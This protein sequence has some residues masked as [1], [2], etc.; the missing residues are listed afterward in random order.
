MAT[1]GYQRQRRGNI[2]A[3]CLVIFLQLSF[4]ACLSAPTELVTEDPK[5]SA[6]Q[7]NPPASPTLMSVTSSRNHSDPSITTNNLPGSNATNPIPQNDGKTTTIQKTTQPDGKKVTTK[8]SSVSSTLGSIDKVSD[9]TN[10]VQ[11][12]SLG[13]DATATKPTTQPPS[14]APT[15]TKAATPETEKPENDI[16]DA[17]TNPTTVESIDALLPTDDKESENTN[18]L[19]DTNDKYY[20]DN[21]DDDDS[22][23]YI[24]STND[25]IFEL[26]DNKD[27]SKMKQ[28]SQI[29]EPNSNDS[30]N[31]DSNFFFHLVILVLLVAI[32]YITYHNKRK[33]LLLVQSRRWKEGLCSRNNVE[34]RRLDQNVNEAM[35]SLKMTKDYI[36]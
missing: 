10:P 5:G 30:E 22:E 1:H 35:P 9:T 19:D 27:Q 20:D 16:K 26:K 32:V 14:K 11:N 3:L 28:P 6:V 17:T 13:P 33:I 23:D 4:K 12:A 21:D 18:N 7:G 24:Q 36:F 25:G 8:S 15:T 34:Y 2:Y 31:Q 29:Y